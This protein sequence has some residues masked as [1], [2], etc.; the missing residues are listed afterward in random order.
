MAARLVRTGLAFAACLLCLPVSAGADG[1]PSAPHADIYVSAAVAGRTGS[2]T[3]V[4]VTVGNKGPD[5][6]E[7]SANG[8]SVI[9]TGVVVYPA[10]G[11]VSI[12]PACKAGPA[13]PSI[14]LKCDDIH[15]LA[16][17][18]TQQWTVTA[19]PA[20]QAVRSGLGGGYLEDTVLDNNG[21]ELNLSGPAEPTVGLVARCDDY[22]VQRGTVLAVAPDE[23]IFANDEGAPPAIAEVT[24]SSFAVKK[25]HLDTRSG[26][27]SYAASA[28]NSD[29]GWFE[30]RLVSKAKKAVS[31][32]AR[33]YL[34]IYD[35]DHPVKSLH[36]HCEDA[37]EFA[38]VDPGKELAPLVWLDS[39]EKYFPMDA[40]Q[41][42]RESGLKFAHDGDCAN[43][44]EVKLSSGSWSEAEIKRLGG[45]LAPF[46]HEMAQSLNCSHSDDDETD[47]RDERGIFYSDAYTSP[48]RDE[49]DRN[50]LPESQGWYLDHFD[51][52]TRDLS[53]GSRSGP[54]PVYAGLSNDRE[55]L[56]FWMFYAASV[57]RTVGSLGAPGHLGK[58][59][60][61]WERIGIA[62]N[63][64][65][66]TT[67]NYYRHGKPNP[68]SYESVERYGKHPIVFS[69]RYGHASYPTPTGGSGDTADRGKRWKS[70]LR[71][72][73]LYAEPWYGFGGSWGW[74]EEH[75]LQKAEAS[76]PSGPSPY[77]TS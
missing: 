48:W 5:A 44:P 71:V 58:H 57:Y 72:R 4:T 11:Y 9:N 70:W 45:K 3:R 35:K 37:R 43:H 51:N 29:Q 16:V 56:N 30:Y 21:F 26:A 2:Q 8:N 63:G 74:V 1:V 31:E 19:G 22:F 7:G 17:G 12:S 76:G 24:K 18:A 64:G 42:V 15:D 55:E 75:G 39:R 41:F 53:A 23:G 62:L 73:G 6:V 34:N 61:D 13:G 67:V 27:F 66:P 52:G 50:S 77:K 10:A 54:W 49:A 59:E 68:V 46:G 69:A 25:L 36:G 40:T 65:V 28:H 32:K 14:A 38:G 33:V 60:G 20:A 47:H